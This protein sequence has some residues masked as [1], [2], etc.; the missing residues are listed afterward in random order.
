MVEQW[1]ATDMVDQRNSD[2]EL[3][4]LLNRD[5]GLVEQ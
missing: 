2:S 5:R 1:S 3:V 4:E